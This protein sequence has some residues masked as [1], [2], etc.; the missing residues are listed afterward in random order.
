MQNH[1]TCSEME[2]APDVHISRKVENG[3]HLYTSW[4]LC[5]SRITS[6]STV[7]IPNYLINFFEVLCQVDV[8][9]DSISRTE[10]LSHHTAIET[11]VEDAAMMDASTVEVEE[12]EC[13]GPGDHFVD[14]TET[15]EGIRSMKLDQAA[16][17][18]T[19]NTKVE[20]QVDESLHDLIGTATEETF[21]DDVQV[22]TGSVAY[23][24]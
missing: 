6:D 1:S 11:S 16:L 5:M 10:Q 22:E 17:R 3:K 14:K 9:N 2:I 21:M 20:H 24:K 18:Y 7:A 13:W 8:C 15:I 19:F 12:P 23:Q 4:I